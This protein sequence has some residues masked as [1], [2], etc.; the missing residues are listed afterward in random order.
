MTDPRHT[1]HFKGPFDI[2]SIRGGS[3]E[4]DPFHQLWLGYRDFLHP[5]YVE[6]ETKL[7]RYL[8]KQ[9]LIEFVHRHGG[10]FIKRSEHNPHTFRELT[11][12]EALEKCSRTISDLRVG[13]PLPRPFILV[14]VEPAFADPPRRQHPPR[15]RRQEQRV[16][17]GVDVIPPLAQPQQHMEVMPEVSPHPESPQTD[18][19]PLRRRRRRLVIEEQ[20]RRQHRCRP[21]VEPLLYQQHHDMPFGVK[22][23]DEHLLDGV[24]SSKEVLVEYDGLEESR[25][26]ALHIEAKKLPAVTDPPFPQPHYLRPVHHLMKRPRPV[27]ELQSE[28][29]RLEPHQPHQ[30]MSLGLEERI[31]RGDNIILLGGNLDVDDEPPM[32]ELLLHAAN[33]PMQQPHQNGMRPVVERQAVLLPQLPPLQPEA[34][35]EQQQYVMPPLVEQRVLEQ[36][37]AIYIGIDDEN[38]ANLDIEIIVDLDKFEFL[39]GLEHYLEGNFDP[40]VL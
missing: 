4:H 27:L 30:D 28:A 1:I 34:E 21:I 3:N 15:Q 38:V 7:E 22:K 16:V 9:R 35:L 29:M 33:P 24:T 5:F 20:R 36:E 37:I 6:A 40:H 12:A 23:C 13:P 8:C 11:Y 25:S 26:G 19:Q 14:D 2:E 17:T 32:E 39:G 18:S 10:R 31:P